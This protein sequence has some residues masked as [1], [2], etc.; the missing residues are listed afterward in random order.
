MEIT[1]DELMGLVNSYSHLMINYERYRNAIKHRTDKNVDEKFQEIV[2][3]NAKNDLFKSYS[4]YMKSFP[5]S[6]RMQLSC[7]TSVKRLLVREG[8]E[9]KVNELEN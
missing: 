7:V 9:D 8:L 2:E 6:I 4:G 3:E 1:E 5:K